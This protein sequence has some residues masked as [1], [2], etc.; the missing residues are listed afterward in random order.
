MNGS[1]NL[2][3]GRIFT[4]CEF[5]ERCLLAVGEKEYPLEISCQDVIISNRNFTR[6]V[7]EFWKHFSFEKLKFKTKL[8]DC[9]TFTVDKIMTLETPRNL[10]YL[11][12][13]SVPPGSRNSLLVCV[14]SVAL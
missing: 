5:I 6:R 4:N 11:L 8:F 9:Y 13:T 10:K 7:K 14:D 12:E 2:K 1:M 3:E